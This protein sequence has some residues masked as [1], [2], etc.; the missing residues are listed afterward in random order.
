MAELS[1]DLIW[2]YVADA[3]FPNRHAITFSGAQQVESDA[4]PDWG[5]SESATNPEQALAA[6]MASCHMMTFLA[7][8][9]KTKW[10][11]SQYSD[12]ATAHL[13][14]NSSGQ[15]A[16]VKIDLAPIVTLDTDFECTEDML[17]TMHERAHRYCFIANSV[18]DS[19]TVDIKP[20]RAP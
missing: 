17:I 6:A 1:I 4:A 13:G 2:K 18:S 16:V 14:K 5:G 11:I 12:H 7:L 3:E 20:E 15:M 9:N 8:A 10:P 19:L